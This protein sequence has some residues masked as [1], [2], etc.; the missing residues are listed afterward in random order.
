MSIFLLLQNYPLKAQLPKLGSQRLSYR[1]ADLDPLRRTLA[2]FDF[3][4]GVVGQLFYCLVYL[5]IRYVTRRQETVFE[6]NQSLHSTSDAF[7]VRIFICAQ[8][9][10]VNLFSCCPLFHVSPQLDRFPGN[11][12]ITMEFNEANEMVQ[13]VRWSTPEEQKGAANRFA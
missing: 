2:L 9:G 10:L 13:T 12:A 11:S 8:R 7:L 4:H 5:G 3:L 1:Y 6:A